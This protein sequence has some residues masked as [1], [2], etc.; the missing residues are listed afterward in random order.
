[1]GTKT[2]GTPRKQGLPNSGGGANHFCMHA[3]VLPL[4]YRSDLG[5]ELTLCGVYQVHFCYLLYNLI[6]YGSEI[7]LWRE[8]FFS[9][10]EMAG[11]RDCIDLSSPYCCMDIYTMKSQ[12]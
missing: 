5:L 3:Q 4:T 10:P 12:F 8:Y 2:P 7:L 9:S 6:L 1:M 11:Y